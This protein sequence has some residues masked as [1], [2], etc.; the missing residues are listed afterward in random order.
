MR[1]VLGQGCVVEGKLVCAGPT[2]LDGKVTG[3]LVADDFL[4][5]DRNAA[6][7]A[8]LNVQEVVVRGVVRGNINAT[9]RVTLEETAQVEGDVA[10]PA[11]D[12][13]PG[14]QM[15]GKIDVLHRPRET[16]APVGPALRPF[17]APT[18]PAYQQ[19][20]IQREGAATPAGVAPSQPAST[21]A[22]PR[23][24]AHAFV[25]FDDGTERSGF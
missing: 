20:P 6:I 25:A 24:P 3:E 1:T 18:Q 5:I 16:A 15:S 14:A 23:E 8:D 10:A 21:P 4:I 2:Q 7:A 13:R 22:Q 11:F 17:V 9:R 19:A 12:M